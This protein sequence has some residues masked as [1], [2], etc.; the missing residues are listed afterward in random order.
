MIDAILSLSVLCPLAIEVG[1]QDQVPSITEGSSFNAVI[2]RQ[3][4]SYQASFEVTVYFR[5]CTFFLRQDEGALGPR[6]DGMN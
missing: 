5:R 4:I 1:F 2:E 3:A 6:E